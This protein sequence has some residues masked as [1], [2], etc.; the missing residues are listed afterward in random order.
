[1][2]A[3]DVLFNGSIGRTD[4]PRGS[5][6]DLKKSIREQIYTLP[7]ETVVH[8]GHGPTTTVGHEAVM[9]PFVRAV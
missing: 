5:M 2:I 9:N 6:D 1:M 7:P 3:G 8:C 4:F